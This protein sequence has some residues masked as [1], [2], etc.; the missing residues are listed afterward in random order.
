M[1]KKL[2]P[3]TASQLIHYRWIQQYH[4]QQVAGVSVVAS[5]QIPLDFDLL[6]KC[7]LMEIDRCQCL[8]V[9]FT[10]PNSKG[11]IFQYIVD[12]DNREIPYKDLSDM[13]MNEADK[14]MQSWAYTTLDLEDSPMFN[15]TMLKLPDDYYGFFLHVDHRL[16][17]SAGIIIMMN[18]L[19]ELY[20]HYSFNTPMPKEP[21]SYVETLQK[22]IARATTPMRY[23]SDKAFWDGLLDKYGE[24]LYSDIQGLS[25]L[26]QSRKLHKN[27]KL[28]AADIETT[29]LHV[30]VKDFYL[31]AEP[32]SR[33]VNFCKEKK[34][35]M[36]NLILLGLRTYL[37]KVNNGQEDITI[38]NFV[39][40]R[41]T[42]KQ[43]TSGSSRT[44]MFPC[45]TVI[46]P[47]TSFVDAA[48]I[49]QDM[50]NHVYM[51][52]NYD[53]EFITNE[54]KKR[55]KTP[56]NTTY[57]S[58]YLTYQPMPARAMN[59]VIESIPQHSIWFANG[60]ATK[61]LYLTVSHTKTG[62]IQFS[63]HY[64]TAHLSDEDMSVVY[65]YLMRIIFDG[66]ENPD[67]NVGDIIASV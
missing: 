49:V 47:A 14:L 7:I 52:S 59:P 66:I 34:I 38:E 56:D 17:D 37:S 54:L 31:E 32:S 40:R 4:T 55:Y 67:K 58:V 29:D 50:Q 61:K 20:C 23:E 3:L 46:E 57:E 41:V 39:S 65:Y 60:A 19:M 44:M 64:Q 53:P 42:P 62:E 48:F 51:H 1:K 28:C 26:E 10:K 30:S 43:W 18:D 8:R 35:S 45:R 5:L 6:K 36:T 27:Q 9:R 25:V 24:P 15:V 12:K 13:S 16:L 11:E 33:L 2:Y 63:F 22:D 21:A